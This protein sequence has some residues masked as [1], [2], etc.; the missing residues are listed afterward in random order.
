M[1][2][3]ASIVAAFTRQADINQD[4][5]NALSPKCSIIESDAINDKIERTVPYVRQYPNWWLIRNRIF[6]QWILRN[7]QAKKI[8]E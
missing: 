5:R 1:V 3:A 6:R 4:H 8:T 7:N 2:K